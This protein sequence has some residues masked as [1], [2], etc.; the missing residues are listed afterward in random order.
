MECLTCWFRICLSCSSLHQHHFL[1]RVKSIRDTR[2]MPELNTSAKCACCSGRVRLGIHC[3]QCE[4][5]ICLTC[6]LAPTK[7][8]MSLRAKTS[9]LLIDHG[10]EHVKYYPIL[11]LIINVRGLLFFLRNLPPIGGG[12]RCLYDLNMVNHCGTCYIREPLSTSYPASA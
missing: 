8:Y 7:N 1:Q 12:C 9:Q 3:T 5:A 2:S 4:F 10:I 11:P 6:H